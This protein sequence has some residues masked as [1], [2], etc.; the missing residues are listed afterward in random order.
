[1]LATIFAHSTLVVFL[2]NESLPKS[3]LA[4][5]WNSWNNT[6]SMSTVP[7]E[8]TDLHTNNP[9][10]LYWSF[11]H[12][13]PPRWGK[14]LWFDFCILLFSQIAWRVCHTQCMLFY[15]ITST[16]HYLHAKL[17]KKCLQLDGPAST[18][19]E[20]QTRALFLLWDWKE[21]SRSPLTKDIRVNFYTKR[22]PAVLQKSL[23]CIKPNWAKVKKKK[24]KVKKENHEKKS[25]LLLSSSIF[26]ITY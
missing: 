16:N 10:C 24:K 2:N 3:L 18:N 15:L 14:Q 22:P 9:T 4:I 17:K 12:H 20:F 8:Y 1:M 23:C 11:L 19:A 25:F 21:L 26:T 6:T 13:L 5:S 7:V